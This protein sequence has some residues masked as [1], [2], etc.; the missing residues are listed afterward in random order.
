MGSENILIRKTGVQS[1]RI[2]WLVVW[3]FLASCAAEAQSQMTCAIS[4][5][6]G[7]EQSAVRWDGSCHAGVADGLGVLKEYS[8]ENIKRVFYGLVKNGEVRFG[9]IDLGGSYEAGNF[10]HGR[11][12]KSDDLKIA[13]TLISAFNKA[14]DAAE[15]AAKRFEKAGNKSSAQFY[16][17]KAEALREQMM[18]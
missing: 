1:K 14:G 4:P 10:E 2:G 11:V 7:W 9:V 8:G 12:V 17:A 16:K 6:E 15:E 5:P 3:F 18:D 13:Q